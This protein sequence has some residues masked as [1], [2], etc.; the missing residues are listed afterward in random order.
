MLYKYINENRIESAP[1]PL[2]AEGKAYSNPT[3]ET[4]RALGYKDLVVQDMP[5]I[6]DG[7]MAI[8]VYTDGEVITQGWEI[9][10]YVEN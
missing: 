8:P 2:F 1:N 6:P 7:K 5:E 10:D 4:L 3:D 9:I